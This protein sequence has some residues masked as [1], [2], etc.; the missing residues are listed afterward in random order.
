[1]TGVVVLSKQYILINQER[2]PIRYICYKAHGVSNQRT[3]PRGLIWHN[4]QVWIVAFRGLQWV[5][6][7]PVN[8][9]VQWS[10]DKNYTY[11]K[12]VNYLRQ[13]KKWPWTEAEERH[14]SKSVLS[15][16]FPANSS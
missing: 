15:D 1:M 16:Y 3:I 6:E 13:I 5:L 14:F 11:L 4:D 10:R 12:W 9:V 7:V 2:L 8:K